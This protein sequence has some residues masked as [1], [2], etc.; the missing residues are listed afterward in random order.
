MH[1]TCKKPLPINSIKKFYLYYKN[2]DLSTVYL[3][4]K[5]NCFFY[6]VVYRGMPLNDLFNLHEHS[7]SIFSQF[8]L[9]LSSVCSTL[10][11]SMLTPFMPPKLYESLF[12]LSEEMSSA[13]FLHLVLQKSVLNLP[14]FPRE[15]EPIAWRSLCLSMKSVT[16]K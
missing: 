10:Q 3:H 11:L 7:F 15:T 6:K 13:Y 14:G 9:F 12:P 1:F 4:Y 5:G 2:S 16:R 8:K